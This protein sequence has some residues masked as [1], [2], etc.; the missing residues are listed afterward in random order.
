[1]AYKDK[2]RQREAVKEATKRYRE[3]QQGITDDNTAEG[4][5]EPNAIPNYSQ[6]DCECMHCRANRANGNK[7]AIN[8]G[9]YKPHYQLAK[10]ELNRVALPGDP[11]YIGVEA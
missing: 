9:P 11:D 8:H 2:D 5:T 1:M 6:P 10:N 4:I 7:H 3:R